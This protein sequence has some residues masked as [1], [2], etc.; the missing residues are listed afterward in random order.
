[1]LRMPDVLLTGDSPTETPVPVGVNHD[2]ILNHEGDP[3]QEWVKVSVVQQLADATNDEVIGELQ[4]TCG[5]REGNVEDT[6]NPPTGVVV[7]PIRGDTLKDHNSDGVVVV[8]VI[9]QK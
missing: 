8:V 9:S 5:V 2:P 6:T 1:M 3:D 4:T 7:I